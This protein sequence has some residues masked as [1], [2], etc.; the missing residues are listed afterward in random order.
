MEDRPARIGTSSSLAKVEG[1]PMSATLSPATLEFLAWVARKPRSYA[2]AMDAWRTS[3]PRLSAWD[4]ALNDRLIELRA[5][6]TLGESL[7]ILTPRGEALLT[8]R[9]GRRA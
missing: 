9:G 4:D 5:G 1:W 8:E 6:G 7:V 2:E 3:C